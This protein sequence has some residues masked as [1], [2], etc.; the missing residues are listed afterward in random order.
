MVL[1]FYF[2]RRIR[3][4]IMRL[5]QSFDCL[6]F[7]GPVPFD[8]Q[9]FESEKIIGEKQLIEEFSL[10][11]LQPFFNDFRQ[12]LL[13]HANLIHHSIDQI[14]H[15]FFK[16]LSHW[17]STLWMRVYSN[18]FYSSLSKTMHLLSTKSRMETLQMGLLRNCT[19][20]SYIHFCVNAMKYIFSLRF[21]VLLFLGL[22]FFTAEQPL[23][24]IFKY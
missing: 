24:H 16:V 17:L 5:M 8:H 1:L 2:G 3:A 18:L 20:N 12:L 10:F 14:A 21:F 23:K 9:L 19:I 15:K 7:K 4:G 22:L 13:T 6:L 11:G